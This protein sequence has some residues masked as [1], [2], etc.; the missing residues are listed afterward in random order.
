M[1]LGIDPLSTLHKTCNFDCSYC[2]LGPS[3]GIVSDRRVFV[4][5]ED[6]MDE[7]HALPSDIKIDYYTFSGRGEPT[8]A[9]NIG[10]MIELIK[11]VK[12]RK[13]AVI[14]NSTLLDRPDVRFELRKADFVLA[15]LDAFD[16][17]SFRAINQPHPS[18]K[19]NSFIQGIKDFR[20]EFKNKLALQVMFTDVNKEHAEAVAS[21]CR[22][23]APEEIQLNTPLRPSG[24]KPL[25]EGDMEKI[26]HIFSGLPVLMVYDVESLKFSP[27]DHKNTQLRHGHFESK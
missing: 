14:T 2:Q 15:K 11:G 20:R 25:E 3:E 18:I 10:E 13:V 5:A 7:I 27:M 16:E 22:E 1:S 24:V 21:I 4:P 12:E 26:K 23:I 8:L 9:K 17:E 19:F 6:I